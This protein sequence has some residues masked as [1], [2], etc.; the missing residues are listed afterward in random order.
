MNQEDQ[1]SHVNACHDL[2]VPYCADRQPTHRAL[3][4]CHILRHRVDASG[5]SLHEVHASTSEASCAVRQDDFHGTD[6]HPVHQ[7]LHQY[8]SRP[9]ANAFPA[10]VPC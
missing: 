6:G 1:H 10:G 8:P 4:R 2:R 3:L 9:S 5:D 7:V